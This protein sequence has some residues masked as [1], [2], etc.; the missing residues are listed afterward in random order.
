[1]SVS[2]K[3]GIDDPMTVTEPNERRILGSLAS[4][5]FPK[6]AVV[7]K[8]QMLPIWLTLFYPVPPTNRWHKP[9]FS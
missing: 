5:H 2:M 8:S 7:E 1:M 4:C 9:C 6:R 3:N